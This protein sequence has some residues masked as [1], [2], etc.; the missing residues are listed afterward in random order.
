MDNQPKHHVVWQVSVRGDV[1][2]KTSDRRY[3]HFTTLAKA[4]KFIHWWVVDHIELCGGP[5]MSTIN[6]G[7]REFKKLPKK[8]DN[9][10]TG[11]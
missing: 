9:F 3:Y 4:Q 11:R 8:I 1:Y 2:S 10:D 6:L 5:P 7:V